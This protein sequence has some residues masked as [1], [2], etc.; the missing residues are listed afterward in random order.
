[1]AVERTYNKKCIPTATSSIN[2][3]LIFIRPHNLERKIIL[4]TQI[5]KMKIYRKFG[6]K[7][8]SFKFLVLHLLSSV[9]FLLPFL[10]CP[11]G[12][13]FFICSLISLSLLMSRKWSNFHHSKLVSSSSP[14]F[15]TD[16]VNTH[17]LCSDL[18]VSPKPPKWGFW[19]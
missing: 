5:L 9:S 19:E 18:E 12:P 16:I 6:M 11:S 17:L 1:M 4:T 7:V 13:E 14:Y 10:V 15:P 2:S 3:T 8:E